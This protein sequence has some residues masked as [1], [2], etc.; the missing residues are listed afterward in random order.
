MKKTTLIIIGVI[1]IGLGIYLI[2]TRQKSEVV[3]V[4]PTPSMSPSPTPSATTT[5]VANSEQTVIGTSVQGNP[6]I[7]YHYGT[8]NKEI[9]LVGGIH[10]GYEWNTVLVAEQMRKYL[11]ENPTTIPD[12][13]RVTIIPVLNPDGLNKVVGTTT[14]NFTQAQVS[15]SETTVVAGR[16]NG[17]NIDLNRNFDCDWQ[18]TGKWQSVTVNAGT[19]AFSEPESQAIKSYVESAKPTAVLVW[20]SAAGGVFASNCHSGVSAETSALTK[21]VA[22]AS[23]YGAHESFDFYT[24]T[25]DMTNWLAKIGTPAV[26]ILLTNHTDTEW[27][28]NLAGVKALLGYYAN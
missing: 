2:A 27:S 8:G 25:G 17:N 21:A 5:P 24:T 16:Y 20:Y 26:S 18:P 15:T 7:A 6:I 1:I 19:A 22:Q 13:V 4:T 9:L 14:G 23:G 28:K 3:P 10:G 11:K 12:K